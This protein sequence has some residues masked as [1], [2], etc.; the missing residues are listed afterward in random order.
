MITLVIP[1]HNKAS[2]LRDMLRSACEQRT[3]SQ[4]II[5]DDASTDDSVSILRSAAAADQRIDVI[6]LDRNRNASYCRNRGLERATAP[7]VIFLDSDDLLAPH[8]SSTRLAFA[9]RHPDHDLWVFPMRVFRD[10]LDQPLDTWIPR[11]GDH[12]RHF[13]AHRLD[14]SIMQPLWRREFLTHVGG[15]D[16]TFRRLQDPE[17]HIRALLAGARVMCFPDAEPDCHYRAFRN[18]TGDAECLAAR[19]RESALHFYRVF[20]EKVPAKLRS[21][22]TGTLY[23][24]LAQH[25]QWWR[26]GLLATKVYVLAVDQLVRA[27]ENP[28]QRR[29]LQ[30]YV[31][32]QRMIPVHVA[33]LNLATRMLLRLPG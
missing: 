6:C 4:I 9:E 33:G 10:S 15:F 28:R 29:I 2:H 19:S 24:S 22:L 18:D 26:Q 7:Y 20:L 13:L 11:P 31:A 3:V 25:V 8:C 27:C 21:D 14:W 5:V 16:E 12:L 32:F 17:L 30:A 1:N 23:A